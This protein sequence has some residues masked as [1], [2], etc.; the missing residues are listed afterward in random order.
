MDEVDSKCDQ[1]GVM[2]AI[3]Y[4][5]SEGQKLEIKLNEANER[6]KRLEWSGGLA[7]GYASKGDFESADK[8]WREAKEN[9]REM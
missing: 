1:L 9:S 6:I 4:A 2:D 5:I 3:C 8:V 7:L